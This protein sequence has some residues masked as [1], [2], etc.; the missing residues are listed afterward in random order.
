MS[1]LTR[2]RTNLLC[3]AVLHL[4]KY[5]LGCHKVIGEVIWLKTVTKWL[6]NDYF[7]LFIR[8]P[9][10]QFIAAGVREVETVTAGEREYGYSDFTACGFDGCLCGN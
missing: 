9:H 3:N 5:C 1:W 10:R 4:C 7:V 6:F 2:P 8:A